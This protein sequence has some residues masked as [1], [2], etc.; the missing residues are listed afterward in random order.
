MFTD[1]FE[2]IVPS[3][4][5]TTDPPAFQFHVTNV[6]SSV[7]SRFALLPIVNPSESK[8]DNVALEKLSSTFVLLEDNL[9][10]VTTPLTES[11]ST[12]CAVLLRSLPHT[13]SGWK[14]TPV[15]DLD[16]VPSP[17]YNRVLKCSPGVTVGSGRLSVQSVLNPV[18][19]V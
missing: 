5:V 15:I 2:L 14:P 13:K 17:A 16:V 12:W 8:L 10:P 1:V 6:V 11:T 3:V 19:G 18:G 7:L 4:F 9:P